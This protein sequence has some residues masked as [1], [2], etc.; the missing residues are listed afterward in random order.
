M[1]MEGRDGFAGVSKYVASRL[2]LLHPAWRHHRRPMKAVWPWIAQMGYG[3]GT[4]RFLLSSRT[5][6]WFSSRLDT[7]ER[8]RAMVE[9][10]KRRAEAVVRR[11]S[12]SDM[13]EPETGRQ[14]L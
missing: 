5:V 12:S 13:T 8:T 6:S 9:G 10:I 1:R 4:W 14:G 11:E 2:R 3:L 7:S